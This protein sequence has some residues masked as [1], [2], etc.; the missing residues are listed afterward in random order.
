MH[1]SH[2]RGKNLV[3]KGGAVAPLLKGPGHPGPTALPKAFLAATGPIILAALNSLTGFIPQEALEH[4]P[5][6]Q[7]LGGEGSVESRTVDWLKA[8][9]LVSDLNSTPD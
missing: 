4:L 1:P 2:L 9:A 7:S 8:R 3:V 5:Q 6:S